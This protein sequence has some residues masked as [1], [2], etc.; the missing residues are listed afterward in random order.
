[1]RP[2]DAT[3]LRLAARPGHVTLRFRWE[4]RWLDEEWGRD[5]R[6]SFAR[7]SAKLTAH[8]TGTHQTRRATSL[9]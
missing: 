2:P 4:C 3:D 1:M 9:V 5:E 7:Y 6:Q 8:G